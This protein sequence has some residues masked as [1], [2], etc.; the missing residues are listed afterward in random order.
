MIG[1]NIEGVTEFYDGGTPLHYAIMGGSP[2]CVR[3]LIEAAADVNL[4]F[5]SLPCTHLALFS[6][7]AF[8]ERRDD[9]LSVL[10]ILLEVAACLFMHCY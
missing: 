10:S 4:P 5:G 3:L 8:A 7:T 1:N 9:G 2:S 6:L